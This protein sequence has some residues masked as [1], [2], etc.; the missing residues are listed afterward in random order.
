MQEENASSV[1]LKDR[2]SCQKGLKQV[3]QLEVVLFNHWSVE[4]REQ[5]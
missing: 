5:K 2:Q 1:M 3:V 4:K